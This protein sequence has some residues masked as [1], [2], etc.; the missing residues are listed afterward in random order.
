MTHM[1]GPQKTLIS[2]VIEPHI[3]AAWPL[4]LLPKYGI[5]YSTE[6]GGVFWFLYVYTSQMQYPHICSVDERKH[7]C[8]TTNSSSSFI[9]TL[10]LRYHSKCRADW[11][12]TGSNHTLASLPPCLVFIELDLE[13]LLRVAAYI[14]VIS[15]DYRQTFSCHHVYTR[16]NF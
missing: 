1:L 2:G 12:G 15:L 3:I 5:K 6:G 7:G 11:W 4:L 14:K 13:L 16:W 9:L 8:L 10:P